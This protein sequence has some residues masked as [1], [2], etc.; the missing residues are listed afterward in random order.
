MKLCAVGR[1]TDQL[2]DSCALHEEELLT[3]ST[4]TAMVLQI[5]PVDGPVDDL[6]LDVLRIGRFNEGTG[7]REPVCV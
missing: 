6:E 5:L 4:C 1:S 2:D 3:S 7:V